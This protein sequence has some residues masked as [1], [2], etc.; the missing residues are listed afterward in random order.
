MSGAMSV[1]A[2][3]P[4]AMDAIDMALAAPVMRDTVEQ[5]DWVKTTAQAV[6]LGCL[7]GRSGQ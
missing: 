2:L 1:P 6:E 5:A 4:Y 3:R 7:T